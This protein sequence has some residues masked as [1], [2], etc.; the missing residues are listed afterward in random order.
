MYDISQSNVSI[1]KN[2]TVNLF[3]N[4]ATTVQGPMN[5]NNKIDSQ[6]AHTMEMSLNDSDILTTTMIE[7]EQAEDN[8]ETF[9]S[10]DT[11]SHTTNFGAS[12]GG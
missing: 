5:D 1:N 10:H 12:K 2:S 11:I 3:N 8:H 9:K 7:H 4:E 6:K